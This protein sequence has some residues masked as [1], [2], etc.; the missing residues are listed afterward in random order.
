MRPAHF[1]PFVLQPRL[2]TCARF[3]RLLVSPQRLTCR[4]WRPTRQRPCAAPPLSREPRA[5]GPEDADSTEQLTPLAPGRPA[6]V[7]I[8]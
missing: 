4:K 1:P 8:G 5:R 2:S 6:R 7:M 3:F